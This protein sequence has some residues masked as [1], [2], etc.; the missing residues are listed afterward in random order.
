[1]A[2]LL[3]LAAFLAIAAVMVRPAAR[4]AGLVRIAFHS[5]A[6]HCPYRML[7]EL[8]LW[9]DALCTMLCAGRA[10]Q[11]VDPETGI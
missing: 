9:Y 2:V 3:F 5:I 8:A 6:D 4:P 1:M 7:P 10:G 11:A